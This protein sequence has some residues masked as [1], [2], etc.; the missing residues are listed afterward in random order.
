[1][2]TTRK[3]KGQ[4]KEQLS[5]LDETLNDFVIGKS[6]TVNTMGNEALKSQ[7]YGHHEDLRGLLTMRVKTK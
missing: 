5:R 6:T 3:K 7:A 1:M 2:V 4:K